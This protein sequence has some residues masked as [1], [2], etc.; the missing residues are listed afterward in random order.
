MK[1]EPYY[2]K[3]NEDEK[4]E[5]GDIISLD[6]ISNKV[7]LACNKFRNKDEEVIGVCIKIDKNLVYVANKGSTDVN[8]V[9]II[10]LG[11][12]ITTS[13][14]LGKARAIKYVEQDETIFNIRS[15]GKVI[16]LYDTYNKAKVILDIE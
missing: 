9:G 2:K 7:K 4:I 3:L 6:P 13:E 14:K 11:D 15:L 10:C 8:V 5:V 16:G 1:C 12:K